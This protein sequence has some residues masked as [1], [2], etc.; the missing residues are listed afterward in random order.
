MNLRWLWR[1][2]VDPQLSLTPRERK[3]LRERVIQLMFGGSNEQKKQMR[4]S[5]IGTVIP[6]RWIAL[7]EAFAPSVVMLLMVLPILMFQN[8]LTWWFWASQVAYMAVIWIVMAFFGRYTRRPAV[9][10]AL[11]ELGYD[12][13]L[14]CGYWLRGLGQEIKHCPECGKEREPRVNTTPSPSHTRSTSTPPER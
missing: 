6:L 8:R 11:R 10:I 3:I 13:C 4:G 7:L 14:R 1:D 9:N 5:S 12:V 2:Y